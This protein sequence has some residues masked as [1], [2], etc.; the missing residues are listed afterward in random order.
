MKFTSAYGKEGIVVIS[1]TRNETIGMGISNIKISSGKCS[2]KTSRRNIFI[3]TCTRY[4][5]ICRDVV[6]R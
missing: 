5:N 4:A 6:T 3:G 2:Y 1:C